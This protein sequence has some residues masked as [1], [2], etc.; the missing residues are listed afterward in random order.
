MADLAL[1][2]YLN[3]PDGP[4]VL[5]DARIALREGRWP[6]EYVD[7][8]GQHHE[9]DAG[10]W[11]EEQVAAFIEAHMLIVGGSVAEVSVATWGEPLPDADREGNA[12]LLRNLPHPFTAEVELKQHMQ[13]GDGWLNWSCPIWVSLSTGLIGR[14]PNGALAEVG[15]RHERDRTRKR[16]G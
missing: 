7:A 3:D 11:P 9:L 6:D 14:N 10:S 16:R 5:R 12:A 1:E 13:E 4:A 8:I 2:R 15:R